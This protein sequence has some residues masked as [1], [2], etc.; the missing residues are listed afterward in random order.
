MEVV[1]HRDIQ[2]GEEI[3]INCEHALCGPQG[4]GVPDFDID[5]FLGM[6]HHVRRQ[7]L[8]ENWGFNCTCSLCRSSAEDISASDARRLKIVQLREDIDRSKARKQY[9]KAAEFTNEL[10]EL[11]ELEGLAPLMPE[12]YEVLSELYVEMGDLDAA[13]RYGQ[14]ALDGWLEFKSVDN[15]QV[16]S[17]RRFLQELDRRKHGQTKA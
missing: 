3:T 2:P 10:L 14:M 11:Y 4:A 5:A 15:Q 8:L 16:E 9:E 7:F 13:S 1:A 6:P 17:A 12:F